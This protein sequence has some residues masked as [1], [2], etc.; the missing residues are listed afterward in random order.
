VGP[1]VIGRS[2][3]ANADDVRAAIEDL[4]A[5]DFAR[6]RRAGEALLFGTEFSSP[7]E[8]LNEAVRRAMD[9]A[10]GVRGRRWP[11]D[12]NFM[13]FLIM[14]M[15]SLANA[16]VK[17]PIQAMTDHI[18]D[19]APDDAFD[20][21]RLAALTAPGIDEILSDAMECK[22]DDAQMASNWT[23]VENYFANDDEVMMI[24]LRLGEGQRPRQIQVEEGMTETQYRTIRRRLRRGLA[25]LG[26]SGSRQ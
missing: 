1:E 16:S 23:S 20:R 2:E 15:R 17:A 5:D 22:A 3:Y 21:F 18:E 14:S 11:L 25:K 4:S 8:L 13:A 26:Y 7:E 6:L 24:L 19:L 12:V 9:G 10:C